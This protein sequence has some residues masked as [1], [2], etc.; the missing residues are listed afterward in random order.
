MGT[1]RKQYT[2]HYGDNVPSHPTQLLGYQYLSISEESFWIGPKA[3]PIH[4][5]V[6]REMPPGS[7]EAQAKSREIESIHFL[8]AVFHQYAIWLGKHKC[9]ISKS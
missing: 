3:H 9:Q 6:P 8:L 2:G 4:H 5:P 7:P 1:S